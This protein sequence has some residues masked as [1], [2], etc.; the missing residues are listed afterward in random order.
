M[1]V[2]FNFD[3]VT[4]S[5]LN[6]DSARFASGDALRSLVSQAISRRL[7]LYKLSEP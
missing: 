4:D 2:I 5:V 1:M 7:A 3:N 6:R